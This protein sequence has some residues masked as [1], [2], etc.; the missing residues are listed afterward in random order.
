MRLGVA[1]LVA[2]L[3]AQGQL[4]AQDPAPILDRAAE[5]YRSRGGLTARFSQLVVNEMIGTLASEGTL[6]Q[7]GENHL[8]LR[9]TD[10]PGEAI[11]ADGTHIWVYTPSATPGQVLRFP[12]PSDP[13]Y[14]FNVLSWF[15]DRPT[16]RYRS[17]YQG[18]DEI[19]GHAVDVIHLTPRET[20]LPFT[21]ATVALDRESGL[22]RRLSM[23]ER[24][25]TEQTFT[26]WNFD[27]DPELPED[28]FRFR[29]PSGVRVIDQQ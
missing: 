13:T 21:E 14:G 18:T 10:P 26:L 5:A 12:L 3:V 4:A 20:D 22:P 29:V 27:L 16:E 7:S 9:F 19:K 17:R 15:L 23:L 2:A 11:V 28:A 6:F 1:L 25:G 8:A 24:S